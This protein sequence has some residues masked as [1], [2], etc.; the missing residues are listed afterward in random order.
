MNPPSSNVTPAAEFPSLFDDDE[1]E[2]LL[3]DLRGAGLRITELHLH[4]PDLEDVF[5]DIMKRA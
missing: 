3:A 4:E 5:T 2:N 1:L